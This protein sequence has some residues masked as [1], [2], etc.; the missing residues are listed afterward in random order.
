MHSI[1]IYLCVSSRQSKMR[2]PCD[3]QTRT[4]CARCV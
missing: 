4:T 3:I 2:Q 1:N